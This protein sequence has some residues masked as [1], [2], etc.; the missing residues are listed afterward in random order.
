MNHQILF[1]KNKAIR[2]I[3][4]VICLNLCHCFLVPR[5]QI[6]RALYTKNCSKL[7]SDFIYNLSEKEI[8]TSVSFCV[9]KKEYHSALVL[10]NYLETRNFEKK[11]NVWK[12]KAEIYQKHLFLYSEAILELK[13]ILKHQPKDDE[14]LQNLLQVQIKKEFFD[15]ALE[16]AS[17]LLDTPRLDVQKKL[18]IRFIKARLLVLK[19]NRK[20]ALNLFRE[21]KKTNPLFFNKMQGGF[22]IALLL[23]EEER[24]GEAMEELKSIRW[25][26][27]EIK[28]KHWEYRKKNSAKSR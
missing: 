28:N 19:K 6:K 8:E 20:Q 7:S 10:L 14:T 1:N 16:T 22:Y 2:L 26:F 17:I 27:S 5:L 23:E 9:Q 15:K 13:K 4:L 11:I 25:P 24:F 3:A 12:Q 18:E 21:I